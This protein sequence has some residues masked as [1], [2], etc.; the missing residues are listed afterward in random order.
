MKVLADGTLPADV[1]SLVGRRTEVAEL[2]KVL[3]EARLVTLSGVGG[4]G[5]TRLA[6][7][8]SREVHRAFPDGVHW[9]S[10]AEVGEPGLVGLTTMAAV[11]VHTMGS[12]A[13]AALIDFLRGKRLLLVLDNC[14][15]LVDACAELVAALLRACP[16]VRVLA[17][18]R[19]VLDIA[20]ERSFVVPPLSAPGADDPTARHG[21]DMTD[22]VEL[23]AER[24][25]AAA[26]GFELTADNEQAVAA[27]CRHLDGLPLAI[28]L[29]AVRMRVLTVDELLAR[30]GERYELL[31]AQG[32][33]LLP[34]QQSLRATVDWS[35]E[36]CSPQERLLWAR[37]SVF[38][39]GCDLA[40]AE[41]VCA[42]EGLTRSAVLDA[43]TGL[44]EKSVLM[45]EEAQGRV[46]YQML[47][48]IR[49][50]GREQLQTTGEGAELRRRHRDRYLELA[51]RVKEQW[52]F[53]PGQVALFS[54]TRE[55]HANLR[56][57]MEYSLTEPGQAGAGTR[58]AGALW[59][60]W[61]VCGLPH[62]GTLWLER[63][64]ACETEPGWQRA[65]ALWAA[66]L[67]SAY[68]GNPGPATVE[69]I[70]A[71][72]AECQALAEQLGDPAFLAHATYL[73]GFA[74][75]RGSDPLQGF[76]ML[77]EGIELER[78]LGE[79][80][81][82]LSFAQFL[83]TIAAT[84]GNLGDM[85][86]DI[87]GEALNACRA[88]GDEWLQ[89]WIV[90]LIGMVGVLNDREEA[91]GQLREAIRLKQPFRELLGIGSAVEFLAW[92]AM[93]DRDIK[94][95]AKLFGAVTV[96]LKPLGLDMEQFVLQGEW[97]DHRNHEWVVQQA[98]DALGEAAYLRAFRSGT[99]LTQDEAIALALGEESRPEQ[100]TAA[101]RTALLTRREVQIADLL[102][103]GLSNKE[104]ADRLVIAQRT[105]ETHVASILTKL[106]LTSRSQVAIWV[107]RQRG[108]GAE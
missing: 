64:L 20:G 66:S 55:E 100:A 76:T 94:L 46:R 44:V 74:Q 91:P 77:T 34:R 95:A 105:A 108:T 2:K 24:A 41:I 26:P 71:M 16:G 10:L 81:P 15:H 60:Y 5:K 62:E 96:F 21:G 98:K 92:C 53:G 72:M 25:A 51:E 89:S 104:I 1:T 67:V 97:S 4:V 93:T 68:G 17:T 36:L 47:E 50:Y 33:G 27:L 107:T 90:L 7:Q 49:Q 102:A 58:M 11:G 39:G 43:M 101:P 45:R 73:S 106:G 56:A 80:N 52:W 103:E 78:A 30:Q 40:A 86:T 87:G 3:S 42:G 54:S 48:T 75:L 13:I 83:L 63:A 14:E 84:L 31:S 6:M 79:A 18:S 35:F 32:R 57:A 99:R 28:E 65:E 85:V 61:I 38:V 88:R 37:L 12:D 19:E 8:V 69:E 29:A 23:F 9:V 82:H 22:A 70:L 59:I